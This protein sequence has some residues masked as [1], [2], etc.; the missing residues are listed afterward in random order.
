[1]NEASPGMIEAGVTALEGIRT[2]ASSAEIVKAV[3]DAMEAVR[4][5]ELGGGPGDPE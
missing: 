3:Y 1:M 5:E 2:A 4:Q